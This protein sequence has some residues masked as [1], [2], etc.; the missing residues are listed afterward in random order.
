MHLKKKSKQKTNVLWVLNH[1][2]SCQKYCFENKEL[3]DNSAGI[4][5]VTLPL[6]NEDP[7]LNCMKYTITVQ[8]GNVKGAGID[9]NVY[10]NVFGQLGSSGLKTLKAS[11]EQSF[12]RGQT[13]VFE[14]LCRDL[15]VLEKVYICHDG[16]VSMQEALK[17]LQVQIF[18][19]NTNSPSIFLSIITLQP[20]QTQQCLILIQSFLF[21]FCDP[22]YH[23]PFPSSYSVSMQ[24]DHGI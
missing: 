6:S 17:E 21:I 12:E 23:S 9:G 2:G 20:I 18:F 7:S 15:G 22:R 14:V 1:C 4:A 3:L 13:D 8:T 11:T 24:I 19:T 16:S 10:I 5:K